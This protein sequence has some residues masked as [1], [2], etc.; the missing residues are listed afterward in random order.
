MKVT[1]P[2]FLKKSNLDTG[3]IFA[4]IKGLDVFDHFLENGKSVLVT[5]SCYIDLN[6]FYHF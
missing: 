6:I 2:E 4:H 3:T 5:F 1:E